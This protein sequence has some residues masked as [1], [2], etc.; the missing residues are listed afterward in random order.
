M[1]DDVEI[2]VRLDIVKPDVAGEVWLIVEVVRGRGEMRE[3]LDLR[4]S[5]TRVEDAEDVVQGR[6]R[7]LV[8]VRKDV[9]L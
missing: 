5:V 9:E 4:D 2:I 7:D 3:L 8:A 1:D 6:V